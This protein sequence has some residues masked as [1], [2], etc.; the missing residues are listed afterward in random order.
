M[1]RIGFPLLIIVAGIVVAVALSRLGSRPVVVPP[2][3]ANLVVDT[4]VAHAEEHRPIVEATGQIEPGREVLVLPEVTGRLVYVSDDLLP[5]GRFE[6]GEVMARV[7]PRDYELAID[8]QRGLVR[9]SALELEM[10][11]ARREIAL[12]E[13]RLLGDGGDASPLVLRESQLAAA[14]TNLTSNESALARAEL[15]LERTEIR[16][17]FNATVLSES[18]DEGQVVGPQSSIAR[19]VGTDHVRLLLSV[20]VEDLPFIDLP[21]N[22]SD[23]SQVTVRQRLG[24]GRVVERSGRVSHRVEELDPGTRRAQVLVQVNDPMALDDDL[25]LLPG[26]FVEAAIVGRPVTDAIRIP[27]SAVYDGATVWVVDGGLTLE[28]RTI[29]PL[30]SDAE[31]VYVREGVQPG[32]EIVVSRLARPIEGT[33]VQARAT[34]GAN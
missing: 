17:P 1:K 30:W 21:R 25:P 2:Q 5:G 6:R 11:H 9:G 7:D 16:A 27:R 14:Q 28:R 29:V 32:D 18:V 26:A 4:W 22:G 12:A 34:V 33:S 10:E 23:G 13:W 3:A 20:R 31:H 15:N 19:I 8:Q 24:A